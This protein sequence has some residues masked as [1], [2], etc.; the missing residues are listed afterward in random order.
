MLSWAACCFT[1]PSKASGT[2][3]APPITVTV[4]GRRVLRAWPLRARGAQCLVTDSTGRSWLWTTA[5][6]GV[7]KPRFGAPDHDHA[8]D[9]EVVACLADYLECV[10]QAAVPGP[11]P[12]TSIQI[13]EGGRAPPIEVRYLEHVAPALQVVLRRARAVQGPRMMPV[14]L[15][16]SAAMAFEVCVGSRC[17]LRVGVAPPPG[18]GYVVTPGDDATRPYSAPEHLRPHQPAHEMAR[19]L[20]AEIKKSACTADYF[21]CRSA[22]GVITGTAL[23]TLQ[24]TLHFMV[25]LLE[26]VQ[27]C[28]V[29]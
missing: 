13:S 14:P 20:E 15:E 3:N 19:M 28:Y 1:Q 6:G 4:D 27:P 21:T 25:S 8:Q 29:E 9:V 11:S 7:P 12:P 17:I 23:D 10:V 16:Y 22:F 18:S 2:S 5:P 26:R 24:R